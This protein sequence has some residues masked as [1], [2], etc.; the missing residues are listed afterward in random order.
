MGKNNRLTEGVFSNIVGNKSYIDFLNSDPDLGIIPTPEIEKYKDLYLRIINQNREDFE[1]L[2]KL[3]DAITQLRCREVTKK[4]LK[5]S[6]VR[7]YIYARTPFFRQGETIKDIRVVVGKTEEYGED[8]N[9]LLA[10]DA[11]VLQARNKLMSMVTEQI[12]LNMIF[13]NELEEKFQDECK[14]NE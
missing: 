10:N 14:T 8:L 3:E 12:K 5:L 4:E 13:I 6:Q 11:F 1:S 7:G 9:A 2:A